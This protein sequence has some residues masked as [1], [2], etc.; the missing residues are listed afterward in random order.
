MIVTAETRP[1]VRATLRAIAERVAR[2]QTRVSAAVPFD[3]AYQIANRGRPACWEKYSHDVVCKPP[4][5]PTFGANT[6][7]NA[8]IQ[9]M[10]MSAVKRYPLAMTRMARERRMENWTKSRIAV[11]ESQT[12]IAVA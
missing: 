2:R 4:M 9:G 11:I 12:N 7:G 6:P 8:R 1:A 5:S 10:R 3:K